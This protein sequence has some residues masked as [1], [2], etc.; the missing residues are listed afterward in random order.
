M[1]EETDPKLVIKRLREENRALRE[2]LKL[3]RGDADGGRDALSESELARLRG[4]VERFCGDDD[5][6]EALD[7]GGSMLKIRA[8]LGVFR[9]L[10]NARAR[11]EEGRA[12]TKTKPR[13]RTTMSSARAKPRRRLGS[14]TSC[15][16]ATRKSKRWS[17]CWRNASLRKFRNFRFDAPRVS[18][19]GD[20]LRGTGDE[21]DESKISGAPAKPSTPEASSEPNLP[22]RRRFADRNAA[23]EHFKRAHAAR[24]AVEA[25]KNTPRAVRDGEKTGEAV[26]ASR[27]AIASMKS[28]I[29]KARV[30]RAFFA[31]PTA[32][33]TGDHAHDSSTGGDSNETRALLRKVDEEKRAYKKNYDAL[34]DLKKEIERVQSML[35]REPGTRDARVRGLVRR[36]RQRRDA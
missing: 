8:A 10:V 22:P 11:A 30:K 23:F 1:N 5:A 31:E 7:L 36:G 27:T 6:A 14:P 15:A 2:E 25:N 17:R 28:D 18:T 9:E 4:D 16:V 3:A 20:V 33:A 32:C 12:C 35:E 13:V 29:E 24:G 21:P 34:R 26:N 19:L